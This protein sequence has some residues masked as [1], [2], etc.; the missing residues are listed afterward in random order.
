M[1]QT[2]ALLPYPRHRFPNL[3]ARS[4]TLRYGFPNSRFTLIN[5]SLNT[6]HPGPGFA[7][8]RPYLCRV[9]FSSQNVVC[10]AVVAL[11]SC[12]ASC[13]SP[14]KPISE[15]G[16]AS[17]AAAAEMALMN[18]HDSLMAETS[19]L[20]ELKAKLSATR[21]PATAPYVHGLLAADAA[22]MDW[23][24]H[25]KA[26]DTTAAAAARITYFEQQQQILAGVRRQYRA[27]IDSATRF[28]SQHPASSK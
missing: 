1:S 11:A 20:Y 19:Q 15:N 3:R 23:M 16:P 6:P 18:R 9:K 27:T 14:N 17:P 13:S 21:S 4:P 10:G 22:M 7:A 8:R 24:H 5:L 25:Y 28:I 12:L 26:P 2:P